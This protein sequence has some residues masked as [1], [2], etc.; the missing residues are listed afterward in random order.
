[1]VQTGVS[2]SAKEVSLRLALGL[3]LLLINTALAV[4][5][6]VSTITLA[7]HLRYIL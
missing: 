1:M 7:L 3:R 6:W 5:S 2:A 4:L